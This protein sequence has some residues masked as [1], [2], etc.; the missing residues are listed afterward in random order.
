MV[1]QFPRIQGADIVGKVIEIGENVDSKFI[2]QRVIVDS[3]I[4]SESLNNYQYI[5]SE[6]D[7]GFAEY[8]VVPITNVYPINSSL[9]DIE[10]ATFP[11]LIRA[12]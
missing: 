5:G 8:T 11:V 4:R 12:R 6:L 7:G 9:S 10:L 3:W 2:Q 1:P